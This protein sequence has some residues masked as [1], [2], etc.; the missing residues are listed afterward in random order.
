MPL[1]RAGSESPLNATSYGQQLILLRQE[2]I[3]GPRTRVTESPIAGI[4]LDQGSGFGALS[5]W[6]WW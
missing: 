2:N 6:G 4:S 3:F 1:V 5:D